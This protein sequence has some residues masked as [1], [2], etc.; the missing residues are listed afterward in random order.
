MKRT[1][2]RKRNKKVIIGTYAMAEED[3]IL[4]PLLL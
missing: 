2:K 1:T 3:W 4:K